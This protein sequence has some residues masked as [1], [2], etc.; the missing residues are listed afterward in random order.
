MQLTPGSRL[1]SVV[2]ETEIVVVRPPSSESAVIACGGRP[3]VAH[4]EDVDR[5]QPIADGDAGGTLLGKRYG[6]DD[7]PIEVLVTKAGAGSLSLDGV[8]LSTKDAKPL[9]SSD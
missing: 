2:S 1:K 5:T 7:D 8:L 9:P 4:G 3:M 6:L